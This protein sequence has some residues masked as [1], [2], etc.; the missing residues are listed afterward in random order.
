MIDDGMGAPKPGMV[1][2]GLDQSQAYVLT[3]SPIVVH[4]QQPGQLDRTRCGRQVRYYI[5]PGDRRWWDV[6]HACRESL[7]AEQGKGEAA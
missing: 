1:Q 7:K 6:C 2:P 3:V 4:L 5:R